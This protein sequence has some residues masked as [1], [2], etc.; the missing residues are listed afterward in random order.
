MF[1]AVSCCSDQHTVIPLHWASVEVIRQ[2][3]GDRHFP[4]QLRSP[5]RLLGDPGRRTFGGFPVSLLAHNSQC[6]GGGL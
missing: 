2:R 5:C 4:L 1:G 6:E 3:H